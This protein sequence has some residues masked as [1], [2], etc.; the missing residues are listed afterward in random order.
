MFRSRGYARVDETAGD[1][2][3]ARLFRCTLESQLWE[4]GERGL[5]G[6]EAVEVVGGGVVDS[7]EDEVRGLGDILWTPSYLVGPFESLKLYH[8]RPLLFSTH[9]PFFLWSMQRVPAIVGVIVAGG[10]CRRPGP[11]LRGI[12]GL[13][14]VG[15]SSAEMSSPGKTSV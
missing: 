7:G 9:I 11:S 15:K 14:G 6:D 13:D 2:L 4:K 3:W 8:T 5:R 1:E 12:E 10:V